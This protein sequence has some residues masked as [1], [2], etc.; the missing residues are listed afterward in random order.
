MKY[1]R[2]CR[3]IGNSDRTTTQIQD[4]QL[5]PIIVGVVMVGPVK[6]ITSTIISRNGRKTISSTYVLSVGRRVI[7]PEIVQIYPGLQVKC[8]WQSNPALLFRI[9]ECFQTQYPVTPKPPPR[10]Q[11]LL[12]HLISQQTKRGRL[13]RPR[14]GPM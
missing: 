13:C 10:L 7:S 11:Q 5:Q 9:L 1:G 2:I 4:Q 8:K 14:D 12:H 3:P 6:T